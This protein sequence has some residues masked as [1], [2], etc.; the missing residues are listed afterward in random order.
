L[1]FQG[2]SAYRHQQQLPPEHRRSTGTNTALPH[3][4]PWH[5][6]GGNPT[7]AFSGSTHTQQES[8][9]GHMAPAGRTSPFP[10]SLIVPCPSTHRACSVYSAMKEQLYLLKLEK[11]LLIF[12][13]YIKSHKTCWFS[14]NKTHRKSQDIFSSNTAKKYFF[15]SVTG[16]VCE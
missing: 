2:R 3:P 1:D 14:I 16:L 15:V 4:L 7:I 9:D 6:P 12:N 8:P 10:P 5:L 11:F 13:F